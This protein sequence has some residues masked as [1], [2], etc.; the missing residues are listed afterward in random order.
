[1]TTFSD[2]QQLTI[3]PVFLEGIEGKF[4]KKPSFHSE[5]Y[6]A[7]ALGCVTVARLT[8]ERSGEQ[9][10]VNG[11]KLPPLDH[12][13]HEVTAHPIGV[14]CLDASK[15]IVC[16]VI[17]PKGTPIPSDQTKAFQ[18]AEEGQTAARIEILQAADGT[19]LDDSHKI[20]FFEITDLDAVTGKVHRIDVRCR[21]DQNGML[22]AEARDPESGRG[23]DMTIDYG[24]T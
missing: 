1:M 21:L 13:L 17:L 5:P 10:S 2:P 4:G 11:R 6:Y 22:S 14:G 9:V 18:L 19:P 12:R 7:V 3:P 23:E 16:S 24:N 15:R 8:K 20:G